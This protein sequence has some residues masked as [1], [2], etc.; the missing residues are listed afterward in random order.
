MT[1]AGQLRQRTEPKSPLREPADSEQVCHRMLPFSR[2]SLATSCCSDDVHLRVSDSPR[3]IGPQT[4][5]R[6]TSHS[7]GL[8]AA[9]WGSH[10]D[11]VCDGRAGGGQGGQGLAAALGM[12]KLDSRSQEAAR[13]GTCVRTSLRSSKVPRIS[14]RP[15]W[16]LSVICIGLIKN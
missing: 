4:R 13:N 8:A 2:T 16:P 7:V 5:V 3:G 9:S 6:I 10:P 15:R 1:A 12:S 14:E 11:R